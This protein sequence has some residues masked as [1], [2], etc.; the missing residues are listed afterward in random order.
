MPLYG[1]HIIMI[2]LREIC[3][4]KAAFNLFMMVYI[5]TQQQHIYIAMGYKD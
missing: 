2:K 1:R 4:N 3:G 5:F